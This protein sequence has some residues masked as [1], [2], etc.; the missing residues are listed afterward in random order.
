MSI[1]APPKSTR[2]TWEDWLPPGASQPLNVITRDELIRRVR[3][4]GAELDT[5]DLIFWETEGV[6]PRPRKRWHDGA[7]RALYPEWAIY[8]VA[9]LRELQSDGHSLREIAATIRRKFHLSLAMGAYNEISPAEVSDLILHPEA[10]TTALAAYVRHYSRQI[11]KD[12]ARAHVEFFD[13]DGT[14]VLD[15]TMTIPVD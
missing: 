3:E 5:R 7:V 14:R 11:G 1:N 13:K 10:F 9:T 2:E 15:R 6:L 4:T 8:F 12:V